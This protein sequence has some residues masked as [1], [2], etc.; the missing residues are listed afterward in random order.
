MPTRFAVL[1]LAALLAVPSSL[2][3][4]APAPIALHVGAIPSEVAG[5]LFYGI[6]TGI[7]KKNGL[8]VDI[9]FFNNGGAIAAG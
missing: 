7:F 6:D 5:E 3:A 8:D 1:V 2:A 9:Q 4:Q